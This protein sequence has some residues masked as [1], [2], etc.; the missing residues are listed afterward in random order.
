MKQ[1]PRS[2]NPFSKKTKGRLLPQNP[3]ARMFKHHLRDEH[4]YPM[5]LR[6]VYGWAS[7]DKLLPSEG[8]VPTEGLPEDE[9]GLKRLR[10]ERSVKAR[11]LELCDSLSENDELNG[12]KNLEAIVAAQKEFFPQL[13][14]IHTMLMRQA[15]K[16]VREQQEK[17]QNR[18]R[19]IRNAVIASFLVV[20]GDFY[21]SAMM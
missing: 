17:S 6:C 1:R 7:M 20:L 9:A 8:S 3:I 10:V 5:R 15:I 21:T 12:P 4:H 19:L 14:G 2:L 13:G 16:G 11:Y 18:W